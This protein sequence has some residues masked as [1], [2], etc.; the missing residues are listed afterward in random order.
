MTSQTSSYFSPGEFVEHA[1]TLVWESDTEG[2][3]TCLHS[4]VKS[5]PKSAKFLALDWLKLVHA[6]DAERV[7]AV[8]TQAVR[9]R[10]EYEFEYRVVRR[11]GSI[12]WL[13]SS[14]VP[15]FS[16]HGEY[17]GYLG[18]ITDSTALHMA[19]QRLEESEA[20]LRLVTENSLDLISQHAADTG[21]Y[22]YASASAEALLGYKPSELLG[23]SC[24]D[25]FHPDDRPIVRA[26]IA[27]QTIGESDGQLTQFRVKH[28]AG[29]Y[30][31]IGAKIRVLRDPVTGVKLGSVVVSRDISDERRAGEE[32]RRSEE[33]FRSLANLS[34]DWYWETDTEG[35][36]TFISEGIHRLFGTSS[37]DVIG[38]TRLERAADRQQPGLHEYLEKY[39]K[40]EPFKEI[41]YSVYVPSKRTIRHSAISGEP[42]WENGAFVGYRGVGRDITEQMQT[43]QRLQH[44][45]T[46]DTLTGLPNRSLLSERLGKLIQ[47]AKDKKNI[48]VLFLDLDRF[49]EVND[50][51]GHS[52]GDVLLT[53]V[54]RRLRAN[55]RPNDIVGRLGGDEFVVA[56]E[57]SHGAMSARRIAEKLSNVLS[58]PMTLVGQEVFI[59]ASIGISI[60]PDDAQSKEALLQAADMA[61]YRT[62]EAG[63]NGYTFFNPVM[64][65]EVKSRMT[66]ENSLHRALE[67]GEFELHY[68]PRLDLTTLRIVGA[69]ALIRWNH[70][71]LGRIS[72]LEFI[73]IAEERGF[74]CQIGKWVVEEACREAQRLNTLLDGSF[75]ISV[76]V[77]AKQLRDEHLI[78]DVRSA[79]QESG[80]SAHLLEL[81]LTETALVDDVE[82]STNVFQELKSLGVSLSVD[83]F[84]TG[85]SGLAYLGHFPLDILKLDRSFL[86][87][88]SHLGPRNRR[89][90]EAF[91]EMAHR[92]ELPVVAEGVE[93][94]EMLAFLRQ[95]GCDE[96]QGYYFSPPIPAVQLEHFLRNH[97]KR[98]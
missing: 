39:A 55:L 20:K 41:V 67:R 18:S 83:D 72:P 16:D 71:Q 75:K 87:Q 96:A 69:E 24:Y 57:C 42:V 65:E 2:I 5:Y 46:H 6:D 36:F 14:A 12:R 58:Q 86:N 56:A 3:C 77:S 66:I 60:F 45:A 93:T 31:W 68:Q 78:A 1:T 21:D 51:L 34:S 15:R 94:E 13:K 64:G 81:E 53:E 48:V 70:P 88:S 23:V 80:L 9:A 79:L 26:E 32:L 43:R 95:A 61:M 38:K 29:H 7:K 44:L 19:L 73:P 30:I 52:P 40:R 62:K 27:R 59:R 10:V 49:K 37:E 47:G 97:D 8:F 89:V 76:N 98:S 25:H 90:I 84:G 22:L 82:H 28:K 17:L 4:D 11:D 85:Y 91:I 54:A 63:R 50:T 33:R 35:R 92:L 74:I